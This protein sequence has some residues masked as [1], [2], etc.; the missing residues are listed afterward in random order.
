MLQGVCGL[1][2]ASIQLLVDLLVVDDTLLC[3]LLEDVRR[4]VSEVELLTA[5][6]LDVGFQSGVQP[7]RDAIQLIRS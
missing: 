4:H 5:V 7:I 1:L 2:P 6:T 3:Q